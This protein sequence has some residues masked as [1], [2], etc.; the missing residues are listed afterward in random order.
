MDQL[1]E[2]TVQIPFGKFLDAF[3]VQPHPH[4]PRYRRKSQKCTTRAFHQAVGRLKEGPGSYSGRMA[5][6]MQKFKLWPRH[7]LTIQSH[8]A[9]AFEW[10]LIEPL[11]DARPGWA[12]PRVLFRFCEIDPRHEYLPSGYNPSW[13]SAEA[14]STRKE[15]WKDI[16]TQ[17]QRHFAL[18]QLNALY[19]VLVQDNST[20]RVTR[21]DR[22]GVV[23]TEWVDYGNKPD[24]LAD[25]FWRMSMLTDEQLGFDPTA[26]AVLPGSP[27][28]VLMDRMAQPHA[29]DLDTTEGVVI[30]GDATDPNRVFKF[31]RDAFRRTLSL[32]PFL[33][34][35]RPRWK[36]SVP[37]TDSQPREFLVGAPLTF[38]KGEVFDWRNSRGYIAV[39]CQTKDFVFLKDTWRE[40]GDQANAESEGD[41]LTRLNQAGVPYV[42]TL[43][44]YADLRYT[45]TPEYHD[46]QDREG[47]EWRLHHRIVVREFCLSLSK[48]VNGR[49]LVSVVKDCVS[50]HA[51][52]ATSAGVLHGDISFGNLMVVP[53]LRPMSAGKHVVRCE[54][55][56]IDWENFR[57]LRVGR[58]A[59]RMTWQFASVSYIHDTT[60]P[61]EIADELE[62][63]F[64]VLIY[65]AVRLLHSSCSDVESFLAGFFDRDYIDGVGWAVSTW[66]RYLLDR[67]VLVGPPSGEKLFFYGD[68]ADSTH[69]RTV[70]PLNALLFDWLKWCNS[71]FYAR[72]SV[73]GRLVLLDDRHF[74]P[75]DNPPVFQYR[76]LISKSQKRAHAPKFDNHNAVLE[77][78]EAKLREEWP[79]FDL[80]GDRCESETYSAPTPVEHHSIEPHVLVKGEEEEVA[81]MLEEAA[82]PREAVKR[83]PAAKKAQK[84]ARKPLGVEE[85]RRVENKAATRRSK[86]L[87]NEPPSPIRDAIERPAKRQRRQ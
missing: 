41:C 72:F 18:Q 63:F 28:H 67:M 79:R 83:K 61:L 69:E 50:A 82:K 56:L 3:C 81:L 58:P 12:S 11:Q 47:P 2:L 87:M 43:L 77:L 68:P 49:Q 70:T 34:R 64:Y 19:V 78:L 45:V 71:R 37:T 17:V 27:E 9:A 30:E 33:A 14:G 48:V 6:L 46:H 10:A 7:K 39:D 62:S 51:G 13:E 65:A 85:G 80:A 53:K 52:A 57:P 23:A 4:S 31:A 40:L 26:T 21:W 8:D 73:N 54:G 22:S 24:L 66:K 5:D 55:I 1:K 35:G 16:C 29:D 38:E 86:R 15:F 84:R 32:S 74:I 20:L 36:L 42:P 59:L 44:C 25:L 76:R 75:M 60:A